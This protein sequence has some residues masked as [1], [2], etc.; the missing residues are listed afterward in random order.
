MESRE[1][2]RTGIGVSRI[3]LG[4]G[5][6][7]GVGSAPAFFGKGESEREACDLM[8]AAFDLEITL[9][10]TADA[11]GGGRSE[12]AIGVWL[13][14]KPA[15]VRE[16]VV[17]TTKVFHS[18]VGDP[19][20]R[21]L[22]GDRIRRQIEGSLT[23]LGVERVDL[24]MIHEPDPSTPVDETLEA[25]DGLVQAGKIAAYGACNVDGA[26]LERAG[27]KFACVQNGYSLL[28]RAAE[29]DVLPA[30]KR[31]RAG[32]TAFSPL[33]G[34]WLTGK[35]IGGQTPAG[36]RM[37]LRPEGYRRYEN[38]RV[39][40]AL[41]RFVD[42]AREHRTTPAALAIAW[43]LAQPQVDAVIVGPRRTEH[44]EPVRQALASP[45]TATECDALAALFAG[46]LSD[47]D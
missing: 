22:R 6:F 18:V 14:S 12:S 45:L 21:G 2:G 29:M 39:Y 16:R 25:L 35:Y 37:T 20:D 33:A 26:Y 42:F 38:V 17:L 27:W 41:E 34:G 10:D 46:A 31:S 9:F 7:G 43:L 23:R 30:C 5:G 3:A 40:R 32:F 24:Y 36:S 1:L 8:D 47:R 11:Y 13:R 15:S 28:D 44:L 4:C 19:N